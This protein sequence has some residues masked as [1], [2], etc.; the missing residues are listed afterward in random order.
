MSESEFWRYMGRYEGAT[1]DG[2]RKRITTALMQEISPEKDV[3]T[4]IAWAEDFLE[5]YYRL[6][7]TF[8]GKMLDWQRRTGKNISKDGQPSRALTFSIFLWGKSAYNAAIRDPGVLPNQNSWN[9]KWSGGDAN[10]GKLGPF[11]SLRPLGAPEQL[12]DPF[13]P[14]SHHSGGIRKTPRGWK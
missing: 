12:L 2:A 6:G 7:M 11:L 3:A 4:W 14:G 8:Q 10:L 9:F 5:T 13:D 1:S